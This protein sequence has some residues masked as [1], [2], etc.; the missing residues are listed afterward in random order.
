MFYRNLEM[1]KFSGTAGDRNG[2]AL[3]SAIVVIALL[4]GL[5]SASAQFRLSGWHR[6][7]RRSEVRC[8][9]R[10]A[11]SGC[12]ES[13][14]CDIKRSTPLFCPPNSIGTGNGGFG[15]GFWGLG[16]FFGRAGKGGRAKEFNRE[17]YLARG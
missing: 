16:G 4:F 17:C 1:G 13:A 15:Q 14:S 11:E 9:R 12:R 7:Y 2:I 3:L 8:H 5:M 10:Q 6:M